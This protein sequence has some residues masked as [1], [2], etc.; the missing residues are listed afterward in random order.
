MKPFGEETGKYEKGK[1]MATMQIDVELFAELHKYFCR[2]QEVDVEYI[3]ES[4]DKMMIRLTKNALFKLS[5]DKS[6][7]KEQRDIFFKEYLEVKNLLR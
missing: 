3:S 5:R 7:T 2:N 1:S 6:Y 4:L